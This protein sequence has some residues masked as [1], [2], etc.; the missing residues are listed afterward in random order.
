MYLLGWWRRWE[1]AVVDAKGRWFTT[2]S[3]GGEPMATL[4]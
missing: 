1:E 3:G 4:G 2:L